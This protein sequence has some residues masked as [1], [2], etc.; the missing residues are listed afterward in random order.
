MF[1]YYMITLIKKWRFNFQSVV[2]IGRKLSIPI[3]YSRNKSSKR[4]KKKQLSILLAHLGNEDSDRFYFFRGSYISPAKNENQKS[5]FCIK[6]TFEIDP[7]SIS[8]GILLCDS[9]LHIP[10]IWSIDKVLTKNASWMPFRRIS[11]FC[12]DVIYNF[13]KNCILLHYTTYKLIKI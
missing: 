3:F 7:S 6:L 4:M 5:S 9:I 12:F 13:V 10:F 8:L 2:T 11:K 1:I